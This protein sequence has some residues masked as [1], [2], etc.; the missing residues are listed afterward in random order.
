VADG[1]LL[2]PVEPFEIQ[3][4]DLRQTPDPRPQ[5]SEARAPAAVPA[6]EP[7]LTPRTAVVEAEPVEAVFDDDP[8]SFSA[9]V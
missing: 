6:Q 4:T 8:A 2:S 3:A 9:P 5:T 7:V 1:L